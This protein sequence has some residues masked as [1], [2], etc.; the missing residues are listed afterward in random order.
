MIARFGKSRRYRPLLALGLAAGGLLGLAQPASA[1]EGGASVYL[2]GSGGPGTAIMPPVKGV[3][4]S[5]SLYYYSG[6]AGGDKQFPIGGSVVADLNAA[7]T[8][9]FAT[10]LWVPSTDFAGGTLALGATLPV[11]EVDID[12]SGVISGPAGGGVGVSKNDSAFVVGDPLVTALLGW[13]KGNYHLQVGAMVNLPIGDY[14]K[15]E[16]ANLAFHRWAAD[17]SVAATWHDPASGWD[18]SG[19]AGVTFNGTNEHTDYNSGNDFHAE[20][21]VEKAFSEAFSAGVQLYHFQ[22][23]S[24][25]SGSGARL[26]AFKG[27]ASGVGVTAAW[28]FKLA[29]RPAT[30]RLHA[31]TEFDVEN[32]LEGDSIFLDFSIP[33]VMKLPTAP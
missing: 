18:V 31:F 13:S 7:I 1:D 30:L 25:D 24:D 16:L 33:L 12:V 29:E 5:N 2:L 3:F 8:A 27:K 19:K 23:I 21:A 4:F 10:V 22:Q 11:G 15:D 14:R 20:L 32:R 28:N 26:G 6:E 17:T 9:D